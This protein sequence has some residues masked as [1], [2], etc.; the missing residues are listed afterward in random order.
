M[1]MAENKKIQLRFPKKFLWGA[2][3]SA[4]QVE[5]GNHNQWSAWELETAQVKAA[6]ASY[7]FKHLD[8]W[9][10]I[11]R[12]ALKPSNYVSGKAADHYNKYQHDFDVAQK[13]N[14]NSLRVGIEWSRIEP[15][16]GAFNKKAVEHYKE[17]FSALKKRNTTP[18]ITLWHWTF[19]D[20]FAEK[21]AFTRRRN[22]K[23]FSRYVEYITKELGDHFKYV[24][25]INEPTVYAT[26]SYHERRWPPE[27]G[28]KF[29][30]AI[31][32]HNLARAH[33]KSY[34]I[35][36]A[37]TSAEVG[38]AHNCAYYYAGDDSIISRTV[39]YVCNKFANE[40]FING[41][42]RQQDFFGLNF[43][44]ANRVIGTRVHN[45]NEKVSDLGWD[46]QPEK[47]QP[48]ME[49]LYTK[50]KKPIIITENGLA[51]MHDTYRKWWIAKTVQAM[52]GALKS[53]VD[54]K[55][56]LHW[57]LLDNF[58]WSEGYWP[59]FGLVAVDYKTQA[60]KPRP[61]ALWYAR[62][63]KTIQK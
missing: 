44:F 61:S 32:L 12:Q 59:R 30:T 42:K 49:Q 45:P 58:E 57:S 40:F 18:V 60:R 13:L 41:V 2:S 28:S 9:D 27:V 23:Y 39:A 48:L 25:T 55:G 53:G 54:V 26:M 31:V 51:D 33:K 50:Y 1:V 36:K 47:I 56:Y 16:E 14:F 37:N 11:Q 7:N 62:L 20:W 35:V 63:I 3:V 52:D 38:L 19:P 43:Y 4:Y 8:T 17:Y 22:V 24:V 29:L 46:M 10:D 15:K 5:G 6:Q 21:G 34:K